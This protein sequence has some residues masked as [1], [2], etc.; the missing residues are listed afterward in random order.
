M[1]TYPLITKSCTTQLAYEGVLYANA[2]GSDEVARGEV[3]CNG[4]LSPLLVALLS[5]VL[6]ATVGC[7]NHDKHSRDRT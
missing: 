6:L 1:S 7:L 5:A 2:V 3:T 4:Q